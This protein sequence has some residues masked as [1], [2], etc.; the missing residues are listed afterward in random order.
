MRPLVLS[1]VGNTRHLSSAELSVWW[2]GQTGRLGGWLS[3][4]RESTG[5]QV[6]QGHNRLPSTYMEVPGG[7]LRT[8][9]EE[10]PRVPE[11]K[12]S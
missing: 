3:G 10:E 9:L 1:E 6:A 5:S 8:A 2:S 11:L 12:T 4:E 7:S